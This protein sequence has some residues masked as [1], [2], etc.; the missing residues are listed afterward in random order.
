VFQAVKKQ[1][2]DRPRIAA[3]NQGNLGMGARFIFCFAQGT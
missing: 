2:A 1:A 3:I